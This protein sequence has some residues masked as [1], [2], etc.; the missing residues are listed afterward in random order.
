MKSFIDKFNK[1]STILVISDYP[2]EGPEGKNYGIAWHTKTLIE[3]QAAKGKKFVVFAERA[4]HNKPYV[5]A[6]G[7]VLV[8]RIFD[9]R[10]PTLFPRII[11]WLLKFSHVKHVH[12][13]S[14]FCANGGVKNMVM[15]P[16]F[17]AL[18]K[19]TGKQI[20]FFIHNVVVDLSNIAPH[21]NLTP[22]SL[23]F[24]AFNH[25]LPL[26]YRLLGL[27]SSRMVVM[28]KV[29]Y[30]RLSQL[31]PKDK[32]I[33]AP[34]EVQTSR[35]GVT[36]RDARRKLK[37]AQKRFVLLYFGF[38]TY[39]KGA[40]WLVKAVSQIQ[41]ENSIKN[42][43]LIVAGGPSYSLKDKRYYQR[44][45]RNLVNFTKKLTNVRITG[46]VPDDQIATYFKASDLVVYPYRD[47]IG[48]SGALTFALQHNKPFLLSDKMSGII[49]GFEGIDRLFEKHNLIMSDVTFS[50][51]NGSFAKVLKGAK[52]SPTLNALTLFCKGLAKKRAKGQNND[53]SY[54][55]LFDVE[56]AK[57]HTA[58]D[59]HVAVQRT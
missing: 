18:I 41:K 13:H 47:L 25:G 1:R 21:L 37:I 39:Y 27:T 6:D 29:I 57:I 9:Q 23:L 17:L 3:P 48:A 49:L 36:K 43:E 54:D 24:K 10:H 52:H 55:L 22:D 11:K 33:T 35:G 46:F 2:E 50:H 16:L 5:T 38:V 42:I 59:L 26:Y 20:T 45:Y 56:P 31:V 4:K 44:Y 58:T 40:D 8:M 7:N 30:E 51:T 53:I 19:L 12:V 32:I 14:E 34:F 28:D 15:L